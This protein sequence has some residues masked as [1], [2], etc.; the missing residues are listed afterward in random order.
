MALTWAPEPE[1]VHSHIPQRIE[2]RPFSSETVPTDEQVQEIIDD[3]S[4]TIYVSIGSIDPGT[5]ALRA[6]A[7]FVAELG[8]AAN[9]ERAFWPEQNRGDG[10]QYQILYDRYLAELAKLIEL[11][12][13]ASGVAGIDPTSNTPYPGTRW[14][15]P[16]VDHDSVNTDELNALSR[17]GF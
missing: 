10:S 13:E 6:H 11:L 2:G 16:V 7:Q 12:G 1:D 15:G 14:G 8:S 5:P 17:H 3:I 4:N 9:V